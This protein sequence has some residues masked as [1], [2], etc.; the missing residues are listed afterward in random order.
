MLDSDFRHN[1]GSAMKPHK[2]QNSANSAKYLLPT[3]GFGI[4]AIVVLA[5]SAGY[6]ADT[7]TADNTNQVGEALILLKAGK[8]ARGIIS[9]GLFCGD[10]ISNI[11]SNVPSCHDLFLILRNTGAKSINMSDVTVDDFRLEDSQGK[12]IK[13]YLWSSPRTMAVHDSTVIHLAVDDPTAVQ[14]WTLRFKTNPRAFE[15]INLTIS[16][17]GPLS[18]TPSK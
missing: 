10:S 4:I 6:S 1:Y 5:T 17:I 15:P 18:S 14:P 16:G 11:A 3:V 8:N 7:R 13:L 12:H 9:Y 2:R